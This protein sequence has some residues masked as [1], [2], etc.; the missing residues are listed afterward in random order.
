MVTYHR[1][2]ILPATGAT[3]DPID[4]GSPAYVTDS[5]L[6]GYCSGGPFS[7]EDVESAG[8]DH[9]LAHSGAD[10][11]YV[12]VAWGEGYDAW[13]ALNEIHAHYHDTETLADHGEDVVPV[14]NARFG[15]DEWDVGA[16]SLTDSE[17][18]A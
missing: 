3:D 2:F 16:D 1:W 10:V 17:N 12:V 15:I 14:M 6:D 11:W 9:L 4:G 13:N 5:R 7:R 8:Y 18:T